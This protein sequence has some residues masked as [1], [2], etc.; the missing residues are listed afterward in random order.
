MDSYV[1]SSEPS[2][3]SRRPGKQESGPT[4]LHR[5]NRFTESATHG[6]Q[7]NEGSWY[8]WSTVLVVLASAGFL[9][10]LYSAI[11]HTGL[12]TAALILLIHVLRS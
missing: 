6:L 8:P 2:Y 12:F 7:V 4:V 9:L 5:S 10:G 11:S 1:T 3:S